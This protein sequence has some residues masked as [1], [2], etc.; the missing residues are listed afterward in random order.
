M[1]V[2]V[3]YEKDTVLTLLNQEPFSDKFD[4]DEK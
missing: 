3:V 1:K 2:K 4:E